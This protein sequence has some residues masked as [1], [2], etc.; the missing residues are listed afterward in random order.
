MG[1]EVT[2]IYNLRHCSAS[3]TDTMWV[4]DGKPLGAVRR[5]A[6]APGTFGSDSVFWAIAV[7]DMH[8]VRSHAKHAS[9]KFQPKEQSMYH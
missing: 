6:P 3:Y 7:Y 2:L 5:E 8:C 9:L 1:R 4:V